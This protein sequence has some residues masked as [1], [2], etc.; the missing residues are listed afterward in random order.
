MISNFI[1][2]LVMS[3]KLDQDFKLDDWSNSL[4]DISVKRSQIN[5]LI[6]D[7]LVVEGFKE[8]AEKFKVEAGLEIKR[9]I[10]S[11]QKDDNL[12]DL[13]SSLNQR[14][15]IREAIEDGKI[16]NALLMINQHYPELIDQNRHLYFKL[17]VNF[18]ILFFLM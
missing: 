12:N 16:K 14:I 8:A 5:K 4:D 15:E 1:P 7:Y 18:F 10:C 13:S 11:Q 3:E 9:I 6:M 17:Q 2:N